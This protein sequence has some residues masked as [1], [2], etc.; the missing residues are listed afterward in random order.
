MK[1]GKNFQQASEQDDFNEEWEKCLFRVC[2]SKRRSKA[3]QIS[4]FISL[5]DEEFD[6]KAGYLI[7]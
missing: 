5:F 3:T 1:I 4:Q 7:N 6:K 2:E